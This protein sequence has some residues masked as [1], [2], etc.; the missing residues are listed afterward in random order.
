MSTKR[1]PLYVTPDGAHRHDNVAPYAS[2]HNHQNLELEV[3]KLIWAICDLQD[4]IQGLKEQNEIVH[5]RIDEL[6]LVIP[7]W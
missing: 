1:K 6:E 5:A 3:Q 2:E 4:E 7:E